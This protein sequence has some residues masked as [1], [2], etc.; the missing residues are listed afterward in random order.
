MKNYSILHEG[1]CHCLLCPHN[2]KPATGSSGICGVRMN[3]GNGRIELICD[4]LVSGYAVDPVEKKPLFHFHPGSVILSV[5]S[6]GCNMRCDFCQNSSISCEFD[7]RK[8]IA[9]NEN[10]IISDA[11]S[12]PDN[13]GIA[14]TYN[15]PVVWIEFMSSVAE[16]AK[17][18]G[19]KTVVVTNGFIHP[20]PLADIIG[21]TD[22]FNIDL[23]FFS[24]INYRKIAGASLK[25]VLKTISSVSLSGRHLEIT[26]LII[27]GVNDS[28]NEIRELSAWIAGECGPETP[29][30]LSRYHPA[31]KRQTPPT[32]LEKIR[33]LCITASGKLKYVYSGNV[34]YDGFSDTHC[35]GCGT[36]VTHRRG[37]TTTLLNLDPSGR[38]ISCKKTI[39]KYFTLSG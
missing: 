36:K 23:K 33:E 6:F 32:P 11:Q 15:E 16:L 9:R 7:L 8:G 31:Y 22:A 29:L 34:E 20:E 27:P 35:P 14:F 26:T 5:G 30:H 39:Y 37:Y 4:R 10:E 12:V 21:F 38:C 3:R 24:D 25:P 13:I 17:L 2:C 18:S 28:V 1:E 19:M